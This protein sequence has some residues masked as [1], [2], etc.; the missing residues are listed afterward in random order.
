MGDLKEGMNSAG[1]LAL[2]MGIV[3][4]FMGREGGEGV[5]VGSLFALHTT[6]VKQY[7]YMGR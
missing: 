2:L 5:I 3:M 1:W 7:T 4:L 6:T